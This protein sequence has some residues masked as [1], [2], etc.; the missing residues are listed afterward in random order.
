MRFGNAEYAEDSTKRKKK[1]KNVARVKSMI[2]LIYEEE[3]ATKFISYCQRK[4]KIFEELKKEFPWASEEVLKIDAGIK[5]MNVM[6]YLPKMNV[7]EVRCMTKQ[8]H[9]V[10]L[11]R[12]DPPARTRYGF[13][14]DI[15]VKC[16]ICGI[17][18]TVYHSI[19]V[20]GINDP[21]GAA[22]AYINEAEFVCSG[23]RCT[24]AYLEQE[25]F[26]AMNSAL[27]ELEQEEAEGRR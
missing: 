15:E 8:P 7:R 10:I 16:V 13:D 5:A 24:E 19:R 2:E 4:N 12:L 22:E 21:H 1:Q 17:G 3:D 9:K 11:G 20:D 18:G 6:D 26:R 25:K 27:R 14:M 23:C